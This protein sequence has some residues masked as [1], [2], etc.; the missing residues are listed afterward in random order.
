MTKSKSR[1]AGQ[2]ELRAGTIHD[3]PSPMPQPE[4]NFTSVP[5]N[6]EYGT[7]YPHHCGKYDTHR[8]PNSLYNFQ[9]LFYKVC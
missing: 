8:D 5:P 4:R 7:N 6:I 2:W 3:L 9:L 1:S